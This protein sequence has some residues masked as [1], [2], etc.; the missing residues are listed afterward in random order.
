[1]MRIRV[2]QGLIQPFANVAIVYFTCNSLDQSA[3]IIDSICLFIN[4]P[5]DDNNRAAINPA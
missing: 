1:M 4:F 3:V 5:F 2:S